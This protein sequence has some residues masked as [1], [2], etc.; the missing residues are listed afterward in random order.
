MNNFS[1]NWEFSEKHIDKIKSILK[2]QAMHIVNIEVATVDEDLKKSTDLKVT[3][4]TGTVAVRI[5]RNN[6]KFRDLTIRAFS[7]NYE[8]EIH[9]LR[10]GF[11]KWYLYG[12]LVNDEIKDWMLIDIDKMRNS[13][14][15]NNDKNIIMNYDNKTGF[16][17]YTISELKSVN[18]IVSSSF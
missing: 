5:R 13:G 6:C 18:A 14:I 2:N 15:L 4:T 17:I 12:W 8:T 10:K 3:I 11:A 1:K 16:I 9:K 7:G